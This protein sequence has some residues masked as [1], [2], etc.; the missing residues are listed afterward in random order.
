[1]QYLEKEREGCS[2]LQVGTYILVHQLV[3]EQRG[4]Q[5][6]SSSSQKTSEGWSIQQAGTYVLVKGSASTRAKGV[7]APFQEKLEN[8]RRL[9]PSTSRSLC[10]GIRLH[11]YINIVKRSFLLKEDRDD[12]QQVVFTHI[13]FPPY[14]MV[15]MC[16]SC[17]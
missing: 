15:F 9:Q 16:A 1:M 12:L 5:F 8:E 13:G 14:I 11:Q 2:L 10:I 17:V 4:W 6:S 3:Q 7:A